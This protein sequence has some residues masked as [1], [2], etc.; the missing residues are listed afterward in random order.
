VRFDSVGSSLPNSMPVARVCRYWLCS[1]EHR[2][3][4]GVWGGFL[5]SAGGCHW[6]V[7][8][9]RVAHA[10]HSRMSFISLARVDVA[11]TDRCVDVVDVMAQDE[12]REAFPDGESAS[13]FVFVCSDP[14][15]LLVRF[16]IK[17]R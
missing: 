7:S 10:S 5:V 6:C 12:Y 1:S 17:G 16:P 14:Q 15:E 3:E 8:T 9:W 4:E 2:E 13:P 11:V